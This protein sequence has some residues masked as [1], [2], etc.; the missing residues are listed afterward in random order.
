MHSFTTGLHRIAVCGPFESSPLY[1]QGV[2][3]ALANDIATV[4][5]VNSIFVERADGNLLVWIVADNPSRS[6]REQIF[7]KQF[8]LIDAFSE[9]SFDFNIV[10]TR[11]QNPGEVASGAKLIYTH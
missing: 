8:E 10:S 7:Q 4:P 1:S 3:D 6:V 5:E 9:V 2:E 11:T